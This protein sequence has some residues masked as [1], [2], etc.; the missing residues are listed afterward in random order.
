MPKL[1]TDT[2]YLISAVCLE[3]DSVTHF[4]VHPYY[5]SEVSGAYKISMDELKKLFEQPG[6]CVYTAEWDYRVGRFRPVQQVFIKIDSDTYHF[7]VRPGSKKT[8]NL[9]HL[10]SLDW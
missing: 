5:D 1:K 2:Q 6:I 3:S 7:Y 9:R 4:V 10:M 8:R